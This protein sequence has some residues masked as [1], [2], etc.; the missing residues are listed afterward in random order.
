M[1]WL[2]QAKLSDVFT[3]INQLFFLF[4]REA[5]FTYPEAGLEAPQR[6]GGDD[7]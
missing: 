7:C 3:K 2:I 1:Y 5:N 6:I 4:H